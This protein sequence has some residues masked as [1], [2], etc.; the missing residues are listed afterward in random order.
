MPVI[1]LAAAS[2]LDLDDPAVVEYLRGGQVSASGITVS[3]ERA[4]RN[5]AVFRSV[6]L[7]SQSIGMLPLHLV[8]K[9]TKEKAR[10]VPLFRVLHRKPN[11]WQ[12]AYDFRTLMQHRALVKGNGYARIVRSRDRSMRN[13]TVEQ[14]IPLDPDF[15]RPIQ[16]SDLTLSYR[17]TPTNGPQ[18]TFDPP[19]VFHLRS[20]SKDGLCG[21]SLVRQAADAIGLAIAAELALSRLYRNGSFVNGTLEHPKTISETALKHLRSY[22][23]GR[24]S[25]ADNAGGTP[26]L[27]E[28]L[29]YKPLGANAKDAQSHETRGYQ[30]EEIARI[31][32]VPRP[33][34]MVDETSWGSGI[35]ALGRFFVAFALGPWFEAWQQAVE[36]A[37][38]NDDEAEQYE[39]KFNPGALLRGSMAD[40]AEY[41]AK[42]LGA[43]GQQPWMTPN[44]VRETLDMPAH[45]D[46]NRLSNPMMGHNGGPPLNDNGAPGNG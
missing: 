35:E 5:P 28:G 19:D 16:N 32:G 41:F 24:F 2:F 34:L 15:V 38:L 36:V 33:L 12:T 26:I 40:Q 43:G 29:T 42:A 1:P 23:D 18:S 9:A 6:S 45:D 30:V 25:G 3:V 13:K 20:M 17:Y 14:L 44:E 21:M 10:D 22:W 11:V 31:F 7:I 27:E 8:D 4:M 37:L 46:G 39:A